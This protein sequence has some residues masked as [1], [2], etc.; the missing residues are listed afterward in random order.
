MP[1]VRATTIL[2]DSA[3]PLSTS[4]HRITSAPKN[5]IDVSSDEEERPKPARRFLRS[6]RSANDTVADLRDVST[7]LQASNY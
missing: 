2:L 4:K 5:V 3:S 6:L 7:R 1:A